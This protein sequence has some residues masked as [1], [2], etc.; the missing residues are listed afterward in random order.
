MATQSVSDVMTLNPRTFPADATVREA[1]EEM[2]L[3]SIGDVLVEDDGEI[4]GIVTDRDIVIR[5][6][7]GGG[8]PNTDTL[9]S[10][11]SRQIAT[12]APTDAV[13]A[14]V[15]LMRSKGIRRIPVVEQG[16]P[17]GIVSLG[18]L[19]VE[20]DPRSALGGISAAAPNQ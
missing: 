9:G 16:M 19:A 3:S 2:R 6:I 7:A 5:C 20:R 11:C 14:A 1:A 17:V 4:C 8:D 10:I 18:D 15:E 13:D 12:L